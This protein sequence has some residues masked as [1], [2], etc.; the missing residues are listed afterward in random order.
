MQFWFAIFSGFGGQ[1]IFDSWAIALYNTFFT[2]AP[3][4]VF[5]I[6][7]Q[8]VSAKKVIEYP[9]LYETGQKNHE[10]SLRLLLIW[11]LLGLFQSINIFF[12]TFFTFYRGTILSDGTVADLF[13]AGTTAYTAMIIVVNIV[14]MFEYNYWVI[15]S[16]ISTWGS[17][18][19]WFLF[20]I[21]Y[22]YLN[23]NQN[24]MYYQTW[25]LYRSVTW[26]LTILCVSVFSLLPY[27]CVKVIKRNLFPENFHIIQ[28]QMYLGIK[29]KPKKKSL[30]RRVVDGLY[31]GFSFS[32]K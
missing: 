12:I 9:Q 28:E 13:D 27:L 10:F 2:S 15:W 31:K 29:S 21:G 18:L 16:F 24:E 22:Q 7:D 11:I 32:R 6:F 23:I 4:V 30:S 5:A 1:T 3:I 26:W 25:N 14:L 17:I 20:M 8:D 19:V